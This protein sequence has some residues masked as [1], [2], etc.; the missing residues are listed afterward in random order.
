[1]VQLNLALREI[2]CKIVYFG[3]GL[4]GK[5]TNLEIVH[6]KAPKEA[7]G[8]LTSIATESDRTLFFDFM[9][10][11]LGMVGGMKT[12]FQLY[13]VPGQVYY[14]STRKL[15]LRG[16]DG[17]VFVAD[18]SPD[19]MEENI[20]SL[21]NL[22][23]CLREQGRSMADTPHVIQFNKRD[24]PNAMPTAEMEK[25]LNRHGAPCPEA[26]AAKGEGV[27]ETFKILS[28]LVLEKV[29]GMSQE[30]TPSRAVASKADAPA[31]PAPTKPAV[32][33][34]RVAPPPSAPIRKPESTG[35]HSLSS[36]GHPP[37]STPVGP[38]PIRATE[39]STPK[40]PRKEGTSGVALAPPPKP[41]TLPNRTPITP[42]IASDPRAYATP[43]RPPARLP[44]P[45]LQNSSIIQ[46][47][48]RRPAPSGFPK[49]FV[50]IMVAAALVGAVAFAWLKGLI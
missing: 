28:A 32:A 13:T 19:K 26:V 43:S 36:A 37:A 22:E 24:L 16:A 12:K 35:S 48:S 33:G 30:R 39:A 44:T 42:Q 1:M 14:N 45:A 6:E 11:N 38:R 15:V 8:D 18:S 7:K 3:P 41:V 29:K 5:T 9:P 47:S 46:S 50:W 20:E 10:L 21:D 25:I 23:E 49:V 17:V 34:V 40:P 31:T 2:N 27:T 4:S